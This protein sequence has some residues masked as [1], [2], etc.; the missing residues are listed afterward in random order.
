MIG[1]A[2]VAASLLGLAACASPAPPVSPPP[3]ERF[4]APPVSQPR[5]VRPF[6]ADPCAG[7]LTDGQWRTLGYTP[8]GRPQQL[9]TEERACEWSGPAG[10]QYVG[11]T[12]VP[13]RDVLADTYRVRQFAVFRPVTVLSIP[14]TQEQGSQDAV[15]CIV[16][17]GTAQSQGFIVDYTDS[18]LGQDLQADDPCGQARAVAEAVAGALPPLS[19]K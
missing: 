19:G 11:V 18:D 2:F 1:R 9:L 17:V 8:P 3:P 13:T 16:T 5:D 15:S 4:G 14:A 7:P 6:A 12:F 10:S